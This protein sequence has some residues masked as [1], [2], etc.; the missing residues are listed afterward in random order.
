MECEFPKENATSDQ[1][2]RILRESKIIAVVGLSP[3]PERP[4]HG[5]AAYC[6]AEDLGKYVFDSFVGGRRQRRTGH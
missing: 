5:V 3:K 6:S 4:S 1:I 2:A